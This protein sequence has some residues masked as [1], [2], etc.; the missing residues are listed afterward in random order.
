MSKSQRDARTT[1][2]IAIICALALVFTTLSARAVEPIGEEPEI[3]LRDIFVR[4]SSVLLKPGQWGLEAGLSYLRNGGFQTERNA[5]LNLSARTG[6]PGQFESFLTVP[7]IF[8]Q[9][10]QYDG[11]QSSSS[12]GIGD[13][14]GGLKY[15]IHR[16]RR[17][18][19]DIIGSI[20]ITAPTG[21]V[22]QALPLGGGGWQTGA[23]LSFVKSTDPA[24]L[25]GTLG[26]THRFPR[27]LDSIDYTGGDSVSYSLGTAFSLNSSVSLSV[28]FSGAY[29]S[30]YAANG[31]NQGGSDGE[32]MSLTGA[33]A[34]NLPG[35]RYIQTSVKFGLND[36]APD[37]VLGVSYGLRLDF[38]EDD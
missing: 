20:I 3:D 31:I 30:E 35:R 32:P 23:S 7:Y 37:V 5:S 19:P 18:I 9:E 22:D 14:S 38:T 24:S 21:S 28:Q 34:Y 15:L 6:L 8:A 27:T 25:F 13:L 11:G 4:S 2:Y 26:Y 29:I 10:E 1:V 33:L 36:D 17:G 16:E 12:A